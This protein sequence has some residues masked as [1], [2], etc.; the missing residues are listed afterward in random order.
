MCA[1]CHTEYYFDKENGNYLK[2]PQAKGLTCE[3]AEEYYD[4]IGFYDWIH[5]LSRA[6]ILKAQHPG[7]EL[8]LQGIHGQRGVSCADCHMPYMA[9]GGVKFTDHHIQSPLACLLYTSEPRHFMQILAGPRQVGK[10]TL[11]SQVLDDISIPYTL[12]VAD[13][14]DPTD[15][16]WIHR[17]WESARATMQIRKEQERLLVID[18]VQKIDNWSEVVKRE[19]DEDCRRRVNLKVVLLGS[20]RLLLKRGMTESLAGRFELIRLGHWSLQEM[21]SLIHI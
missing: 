17:V 12:E 10:T 7:Y 5:P 9:D 19:W 1:Q 18:E 4:S 6:K 16:D 3:A 21:L 14:V 13:A 11:V 2:F 15:S 20:S 8:Y